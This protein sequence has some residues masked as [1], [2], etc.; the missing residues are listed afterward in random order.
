M[1][2]R[3]HRRLRIDHKLVLSRAAQLWATLPNKTEQRVPVSTART[4]SATT[5]L[6]ADESGATLFLNSATEFAVTLPAPALGLRFE[7]VVAAAPS[8]ASYTVVSSGS[9]NI[10]KGHVL[11]SEVTAAGAADSETSGGDT[12]SFVDGQAVVG[13]KAVLVSDG[14]SWFV[15]AS[16]KVAAG[17]T[18]TTAS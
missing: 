7:F 10:V 14:T 12:L 9:S 17:I 15:Q 13:D 2:D 3:I 8:G 1:L 6:T 16:A 11:T 18:I 5:T 4:L